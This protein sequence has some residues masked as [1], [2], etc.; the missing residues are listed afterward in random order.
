[1]LADRPFVALILV[2]ALGMS[3]LFSYISGAPFVLQQQYG[4]SQQLFAV[5][6]GVGAV[7]VIGASQLNVVLLRRFTTSRIVLVALAGAT[8][9]GTVLTTLAVTGT[10]GLPGFMVALWCVLGSVGFVLPNAPALALSRHGEAA[11]TAAAL[12]GAG[13]FGLGALIS[14]LVGALG[15]DAL[16]MAVV[17]TGGSAIALVTLTAVVSRGRRPRGSLLRASV[18]T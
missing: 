17:M 7:A 9:F 10:G 12:L 4:L 15:N 2:G 18:P 3:T 13:Q 16:A 5:M 6:F 14:P 1:M 8:A 11:G